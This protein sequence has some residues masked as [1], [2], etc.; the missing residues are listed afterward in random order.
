MAMCKCGEQLRR[1][2]SLMRVCPGCGRFERKQKIDAAHVV[3]LPE[4]TEGEK[5]ARIEAARQWAKDKVAEWEE[6]HGTAYKERF[7][8]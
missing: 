7:Q 8:I 2:E 4:E 1:A 6:K 5:A 3:V